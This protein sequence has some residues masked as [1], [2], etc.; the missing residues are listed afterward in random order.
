MP[1]RDCVTEIGNIWKDSGEKYQLHSVIPSQPE[2]AWKLAEPN[3]LFPV[4]ELITLS[5][6]SLQ[7]GVPATRSCIQPLS[8]STTPKRSRYSLGVTDIC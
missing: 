7:N 8:A 3:R 1:V 5:R 6:A 4:L 2:K